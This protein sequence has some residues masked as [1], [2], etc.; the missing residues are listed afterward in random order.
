MSTIDIIKQVM[1]AQPELSSNGFRY[2]A[3]GDSDEHRKWR[4]HMLT[5]HSVDGFERA[6]EYL[7]T[8]GAPLKAIQR[9]YPTSYGWKHVAERWQRARK[10]GTDCY[11]SAISLGVRTARDWRL[12][13]NCC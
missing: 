6:S 1:K 8:R 7:A 10:P 11:I 13:P 5:Q 12:G 2:R 3:S 4:D 9:R